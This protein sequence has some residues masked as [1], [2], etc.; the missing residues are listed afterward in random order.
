MPL[1]RLHSLLAEYGSHP[2][3]DI[4]VDGQ[5]IVKGMNAV[6]CR[7]RWIKISGHI[8]PNT[9]VLDIGSDVGYFPLK[10]SQ[11]YPDVLTISIEQSEKACVIQS[12]KM[13]LNKINNVVVCNH[14]FSLDTLIRLDAITCPVDTVLLLNALHHQP[15]EESKAWLPYL[16]KIAPTIIVEYPTFKGPDTSTGTEYT[17]FDSEIKKYYSHTEVISEEEISPNQTRIILKAWNDNIHRTQLGPSYP[18]YSHDGYKFLYMNRVHI[19]EYCEGQWVLNGKLYDPRKKSGFIPG[20]SVFTL[21]FWKP[22][23]PEADWWRKQ[24]V[25]AYQKLIDSGESIDDIRLE[26]LLVT[27]SG[28]KAIDWYNPLAHSDYEKELG[29]IKKLL[30]NMDID[31]IVRIHSIIY[32]T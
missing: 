20:F 14:R 12:E 24:T 22:V 11:Q 18:G 23:Y 4:E 25:E 13:K 21:L 8:R 26:N 3:Q 1:T 2:Y 16:A 10:I 29:I 28:I 9:V 27:A 31:T 30:E 7:K 32:K 6:D 5:V 15:L 17:D 19:L